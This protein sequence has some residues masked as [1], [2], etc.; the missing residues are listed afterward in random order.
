MVV[1]RS[2]AANEWLAIPEGAVR[3][4]LGDPDKGDH[5]TCGPGPFSMASADV[6]SDQ[7]AAAGFSDIAFA[8][9][10]ADVR[11]GADLDAAVEFALTVGP[12]G[13]RLRF[14]GDARRH[15]VTAAVRA[16]LAPYARRDGVYAR[17]STWLVTAAA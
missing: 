8:R 12:A 14:A 11:L 15:E 7:L 17:S 6:T 3:G 13:E 5:V 1:W 9:S 4:V 2:K 10:D 16:A